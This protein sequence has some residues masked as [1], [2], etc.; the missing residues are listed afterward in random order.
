MCKETTKVVSTWRTHE[1][2]WTQWIEFLLCYVCRP[3][4]AGLPGWALIQCVL[5]LRSITA[6]HMVLTESSG[7]IVVIVLGERFGPRAE[8]VGRR[9]GSAS[10]PREES[11]SLGSGRRW[12]MGLH[13]QRLSSLPEVWQSGAASLEGRCSPPLALTRV[14]K[15]DGMLDD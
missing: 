7:H 8:V 15:T 5:V 6:G 3:Q 9:T 2:S 14:R 11:R 13:F 1:T 4:C 10:E 12:I